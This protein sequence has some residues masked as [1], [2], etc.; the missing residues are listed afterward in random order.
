[1]LSIA[2]RSEIRQWR[3]RE[4]GTEESEPDWAYLIGKE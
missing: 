3:A 2:E 1:M 4:R